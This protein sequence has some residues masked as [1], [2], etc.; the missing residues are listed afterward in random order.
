MIAART[1]L[2]EERGAHLATISEGLPRE[3]PQAHIRKAHGPYVDE[4]ERRTRFLKLWAAVST[5]LLL[6][7]VILVLVVSPL[8]RIIDIAILGCA[9]SGFE[10]LARR[11]FLSFLA[12]LALLAAVVA[13]GVGLILLFLR[14]GRIAL[15]VVIGA[16]ALALLIA[17]LRTMDQH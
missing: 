13:L 14:H 1:A 6:S 17:N 4:Q 2:V 16:A 15:S 9:F 12:S 8:A 3:A 11:R 7:S 10:A 5:P